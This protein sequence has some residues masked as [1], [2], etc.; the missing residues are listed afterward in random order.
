MAAPIYPSRFSEQSDETYGRGGGSVHSG[1][2]E[3][4][5]FASN[6]FFG[7]NLEQHRSLQ[8]PS[9]LNISTKMRLSSLA[10]HLEGGWCRVLMCRRKYSVCKCKIEVKLR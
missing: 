7:R 1:S 9:L 3:G 6:S 8:R 10:T 5:H 4:R 2:A